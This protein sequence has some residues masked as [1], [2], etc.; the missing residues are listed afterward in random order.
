MKRLQL[1]WKISSVE[2]LPHFSHITFKD[3]LQ[4]NRFWLLLSYR[5]HSIYRKISLSTSSC[6]FFS[7]SH[8]FQ[9]RRRDGNMHK[10]ETR[11]KK[12]CS[13]AIKT[14]SSLRISPFV[15]AF[16]FKWII[17]FYDDPLSRVYVNKEE[18]G[19]ASLSF[20]FDRLS[21]YEEMFFRRPNIYKD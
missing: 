19:I 7:R 18:Q 8:T 15:Y 14:C 5:R 20:A 9:L 2:R 6:S 17:I 1:L 3:S 10:N 11:E 21:S 16:K 13:F 4:F 12:F